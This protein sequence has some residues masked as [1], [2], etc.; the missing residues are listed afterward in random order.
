MVEKPSQYVITQDTFGVFRKINADRPLI[1]VDFQNASRRYFNEIETSLRQ[2]FGSDIGITKYYEDEIESRLKQKVIPE[3]KE[4]KNAICICLDRY[5]LGELEM[6]EEFK[7]QFYRFS[8]CRTVDGKRVPRQGAVTFE[9]QLKQLAELVPDIEQKSVIVVDDGLFTGGTVEEFVSLA[10]RNGVRLNLKKVIGFIGGKERPSNLK[11]N[12]ET[13]EPIDDL[14]D[15]IDVRDFSILGGKKLS[16]S[17]RNRVISAIPYIYP[18]SDGRSASLDKSPK[19]YDMSIE[20]IKAFKRLIDSY[21]QES[22]SVLTFKDLVKNGFPLPTN[23]LKTIPVSINEN[24]KDYLDK[25]L[26]IIEQERIRDVY[27]FDMDGTLYQL[28][29]ERNRF[30]GSSLEKAVLENAK[31]FIIQM[32]VVSDE[33]AE[34]ILRAALQDEIGISRFLFNRY[35]ITRTD[36]FNTVWNLDPEGK[37]V[38]F[39]RSVRAIKAIKEQCPSCKLVLLTSAPKVWAEKVLTFLGLSNDFELVYS[40][41]QFGKKD[42]VFAMIIGRYKGNIT[43]IGD[44]NETDI[45][46]AK[47][48]GMDSLL[49][50]TPDDLELLL[51][52]DSGVLCH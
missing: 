42:E 48:L 36:Y 5:L 35:G 13:I 33:I 21:E 28:D 23:V 2:V 14:Y 27:I 46:P 9:E 34:E 49:V 30:S 4:N 51:I 44:Q 18:W 20:V 22:G 47:R 41:E 40:G 17:R 11:T 45:L 25:C 50:T 31:R 1:N 19:F 24:V 32:E 26:F 38:N 10:N 16:G 52:D 3:L 43:S 15:W 8:I 12:I 29:G 39:E 6:D 7:S 37:V